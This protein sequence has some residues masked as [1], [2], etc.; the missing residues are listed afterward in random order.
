VELSQVPARTEGKDGA[1]PT[2]SA[3]VSG[4]LVRATDGLVVRA[5]DVVERE[6]LIPHNA[7]L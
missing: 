7:K 5:E 2:S 3:P 4:F 6:Y 1:V